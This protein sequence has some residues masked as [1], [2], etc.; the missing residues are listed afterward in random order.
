MDLRITI[1]D[2]AGNVVRDEIVKAAEATQQQI[3]EMVSMI[4]GGC[5]AW[6][7]AAAVING[8]RE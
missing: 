6:M 1:S 2:A 3:D 5:P 4:E 7:A 8:P